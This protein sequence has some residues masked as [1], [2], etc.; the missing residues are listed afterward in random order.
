MHTE[1]MTVGKRSIPYP[2]DDLKIA[3]P[4]G[5]GPSSAALALS[6]AVG[7]REGKLTQHIVVGRPVWQ[8]SDPRAAAQ[9]ILTGLPQRAAG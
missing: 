7:A 1:S 4:C 8:S 3:I 9:A 5:G 6:L 2:R